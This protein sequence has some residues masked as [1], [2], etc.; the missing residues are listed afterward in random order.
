M[1]YRRCWDLG[2]YLALGKAIISTPLFNDLP[3]PLTHGINIHF[4]ENDVDSIKEAVSYIIAN[5]D[6]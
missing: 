3:A 4:V 1:D 6:Y 2:E 5:P